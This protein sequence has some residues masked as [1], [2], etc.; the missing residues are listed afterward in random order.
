MIANLTDHR[1]RPLL[2]PGTPYS[3]TRPRRWMSP[4]RFYGHTAMSDTENERTTPRAR[5]GPRH[6]A[7]WRRTDTEVA[8]LGARI[9]EGNWQLH[10]EQLRECLKL[11]NA[12][13]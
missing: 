2:R 11:T 9:P 12:L 4:T 6:K 1:A 10:M 7:L 8:A 5:I 13:Y 3:A